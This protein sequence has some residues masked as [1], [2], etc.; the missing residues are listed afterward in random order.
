MRNP[1]LREAVLAKYMPTQKK[2]TYKYLST[3]IKPSTLEEF[4]REVAAKNS[5]YG[6]HSFHNK[7]AQEIEA[8]FA[9]NRRLIEAQRTSKR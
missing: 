3:A 2:S 9:Q 6:E 4:Y 7:N 5:I 8:I 1:I